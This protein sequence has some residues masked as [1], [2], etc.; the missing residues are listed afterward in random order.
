MT[1]N[2]IKLLVKELRE[3]ADC[4]EAGNSNLT[5]EE[6]IDLFGVIA[7]QSMSKEE[8]CSYL[9]ISRATFDNYIR[10]GFLPKGRKERGKTNLV[11]YKDELVKF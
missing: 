7:H 11:W 2:L 10:D 6:A 9:N 1:K 3:K 5:E 8:A 4:I